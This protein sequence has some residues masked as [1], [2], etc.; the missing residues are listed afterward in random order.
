MTVELKNGFE[1]LEA[2]ELADCPGLKSTSVYTQ[3]AWDY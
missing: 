1:R 2:R 3:D